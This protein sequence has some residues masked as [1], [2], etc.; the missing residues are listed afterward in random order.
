MPASTDKQS[1]AYLAQLPR[2][3]QDYGAAWIVMVDAAVKAHF[4]EFEQAADYAIRN[5]PDSQFM[6]R[7][8][9]E[10]PV[11]VTYIMVDE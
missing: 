8:T 5:F 6:I 4:A 10:R 3:R 2:L 9:S 7:H 11:E 1:E